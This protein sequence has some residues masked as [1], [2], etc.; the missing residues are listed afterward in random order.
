MGLN[1]TNPSPQVNNPEATGP[2][3][4]DGNLS[5]AQRADLSPQQDLRGDVSQLDVTRRSSWWCQSFAKRRITPWYSERG[6]G[7]TRRAVAQ[8]RS[9]R[10]QLDTR[11]E[12]GG[13]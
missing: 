13:A 10:S 9:W 4:K 12:G 1:N 5:T 6:A 11:D 8:R 2:L 7:V 3:W